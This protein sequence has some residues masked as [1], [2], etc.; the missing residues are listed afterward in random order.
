M[1][2]ATPFDTCSLTTDCEPCAT[3][4]EISSPSFK[5]NEP[6]PSQF[7][8]DGKNISPAL[9]IGDI[10]ANTKSLALIVDDPDAPMG[11]WVHWVVFDISVTDRG[12]GGFGHT[13]I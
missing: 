7:T 8:C 9:D 10:P 12:A 13:G 3:P 4:V 11:T 1:R 2:T 6:I 5:N